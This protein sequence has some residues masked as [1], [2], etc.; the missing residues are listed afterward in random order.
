LK[1]ILI[2]G[3]FLCRQLTGIERY[4]YEISIRLDKISKYHEIAIIIP[5]NTKNIPNFINFEIIRHKKNI[6]SHLYWQMV[7]LQF[8]LLCHKKYVVLDF[9]NTCLPFSPG[10]TFLHDIYCEFF[11]E[12]FKTLRDKI[13]RIYNRCQYRLICKKAKMIITVSNFTK[14]QVV[15]KFRIDGGKIKVVYSSWE[16]FLNIRPDYAVF[17]EYP[18]LNEKK[19]FFSLGSLS[20]RKNLKWIVEYAAKNPSVIF[21]LSGTSL[22]TVKSNIARETESLKNILLLGYLDDSKIRA[23]M[24]K[25]TAFILPSYYEGF[26][27][28]P[29]EA[30]STGARVIVANSSSLPE[31]Y[32]KTAHY[33]DPYNI[34]VDLDKLLSE[35][36][37]PPDRILDLYSYNKSSKQVYNL[38]KEVC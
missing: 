4:A 13:I 31:I 2:N 22:P 1:K 34:N 14:S 24:E 5:N 18:V 28:T 21:A 30:L 37:E 35:P 16:H 8:F 17:K 27:L 33:I 19:Y 12:D 3:D 32:G 36:V 11:P 7:T 23:L 6:N 9:G 15:N 10:I 29:L 20:K 26:G 38:I 25:C